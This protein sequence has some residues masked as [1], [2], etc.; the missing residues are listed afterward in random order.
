MVSPAAVLLAHLAAARRRGEAFEVAWPAAVAAALRVAPRD[1]CE[2]WH[3][4]LAGT[5]SSWH[6]AWLRHPPTRA[7]RALR[8]VAEDP[9]RVPLPERECER[10]HGEI[11]PERGRGTRV[12]YCSSEC[13]EAANAEKQLRYVAA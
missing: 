12:R 7:E 13:K 1:E 11:P 3:D 9:D 4:A 2:A 6:E 8:S 5:L 10:C